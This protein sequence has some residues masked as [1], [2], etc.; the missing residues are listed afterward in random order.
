M[1][2]NFLIYRP[3][4]TACANNGT[5]P[6]W[7]FCVSW[8]LNEEIQED[9]HRG[10]ERRPQRGRC[11]AWRI[12]DHNGVQTAAPRQQREEVSRGMG[13]KGSGKHQ[14]QVIDERITLRISRY[15][16]LRSLSE[17][18][19]ALLLAYVHPFRCVERVPFL[20][21]GLLHATR[22]QRI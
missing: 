14:K 9:S 13:T 12:T 15:H 3:Q 5:F 7:W 20:R 8:G 11:G 2:Y 22:N 18:R 16:Q 10:G 19:F 6:Y 4:S 17:L 21:L 1:N